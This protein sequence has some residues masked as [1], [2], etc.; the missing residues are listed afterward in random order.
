MTRR[1]ML[2]A[3]IFFSAAAMLATAD[4]AWLL[5][6][7][8]GDR[9]RP[10]PYEGEAEAVAAGHN[11]FLEHC[12]KCHGQNAQGVKKRPSLHSARVQH[13]ATPG[14]LHWLLVNGSMK[15]GMPPW[16]KLPDAQLWQLVSFLKSLHD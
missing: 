14:D 8:P 15:K 7:P 11:I 16:A 6:V 2:F 12:A 4:G 3:F 1:L 10:N 13:Q 5:R 9:Q